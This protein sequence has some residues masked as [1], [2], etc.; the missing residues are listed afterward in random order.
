MARETSEIEDDVIG[1]K[2]EGVIR[3]ALGVDPLHLTRRRDDSFG[4]EES[5]REF[6]IVS[7]GAHHHS[8]G[9][10]ADLDFERLLPCDGIGGV[11]RRAFGV[12][13]HVD[14]SE[15]VVAHDWNPV[16]A[17]SSRKVR[18]TSQ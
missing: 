9:R 7:R 5:H 4:Q 11:S 18:Q 8:Q 1:E 10:S 3:F 13:L 6:V 2:D 15:G 16:G 17:T 14:P 12:P